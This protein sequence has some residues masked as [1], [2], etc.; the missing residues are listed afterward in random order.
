MGQSRRVNLM[1]GHVFCSGGTHSHLQPLHGE[2][3][4]AAAAAAAALAASAAAA[5]RLG[6]RRRRSSNFLLLS[7]PETAPADAFPSHFKLFD[8]TGSL[9][10]QDV[11]WAHGWVECDRSGVSCCPGYPSGAGLPK[12]HRHQDK[13][14]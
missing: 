7:R 3:S 13:T 12:A 8:V 6:C 14:P 10:R 5:G 1:H 2:H 9:Q 11:S 4:V